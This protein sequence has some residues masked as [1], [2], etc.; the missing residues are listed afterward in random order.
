MATAFSDEEK[1][2]IEESLYEAAKKCLQKFGVK[3]TT[4]ERIT[5][6][7][8]ISKGSVY[9]FYPKKE[10][11]FFKVLEEYQNDVMNDF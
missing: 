5:Q 11:L 8:G 3:K 1:I 7:A 4:V 10:I 2:E 9:N 6:M